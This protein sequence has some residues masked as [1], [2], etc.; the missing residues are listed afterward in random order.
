MA[1]PEFSPEMRALQE[2]FETRRLAD[3]VAEHVFYEQFTDADREFVEQSMFMFIATTDGSGQPQ[4]SYKGGP[5]GFVKVTGPSELVFPFYEGNGLFLSAGNIAEM[6]KIGLLFIDFE[7]Q[8]RMRV[9]GVAE[10]LDDHPALEGAV[11]A[12]LAVRVAVTDIHP[13]CL[14]NVHKMQFVESSSF[15][16]KSADEDVKK[17]P[18]SE[19]FRD[20]LPE[21]MKPDGMKE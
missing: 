17:A 18:W 1:Q 3:K 4:C 8:K 14:R 19:T 10:I 6:S 9:N 13:N 15:T 20:V 21:Q 2:Q 11:A 5:R 12:Q 16:P 7:N